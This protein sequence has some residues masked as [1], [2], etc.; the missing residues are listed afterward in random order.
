MI[1]GSKSHFIPDEIEI[2]K[3]YLEEGGSLLIFQGEGGDS[4]N[5][6]NLNEIIKD[7]GIS[8]HGDTIVRTSY[9][10]YFHPKE[11]F[12][13]TCKVH[14]EF[15]KSIKS[16][17]KKKRIDL[18][19]NEDDEEWDDALLK[20]VYPYGQTLECS[21]TTTVIFN[22][23]II[24][25]P[26]N[27][28]LC[29]V[30]QSKSGK[31]KLVVIGSLKFIDNDYIDKEE[32]RKVMEGLIKWLL[33]L[34]NPAITRPAKEV[35]IS[36]YIYIPNIISLSDKVKSCLEEAKEPPRNFND[37]FDMN[38]FK[39]D[40]SLVPEAI[41]LY[42]KL[43]VKHETLSIIPPQF[44]TPLPPLQLAVFDPIIKEFPVPNLELFDLDEQ[45]ASEKIKLAQMTNKCSDED[46]E[47]YIKECSDILGITGRLDNRQDSKAILSFVMKELINFKKLN[48]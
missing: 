22:S 14:P 5:N 45:F 7:Y 36:E 23:G 47:Y 43:N 41:E 32:N 6:T 31:G 35:E 25:Y 21:P 17:T 16:G 28:P 20:I 26:M 30:T 44:E 27:R 19:E 24:A 10:K 37:L 18:L 39:I 13:D 12:I 33:G 11:C 15:L 3:T 42:D 46:L 40:N 8:F 1:A 34:I 48:P 2:L 38:L 9:F 29:A 4:K